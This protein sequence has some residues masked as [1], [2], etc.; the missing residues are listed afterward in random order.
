[1]ATTAERDKATTMVRAN[2]LYRTPVAPPI[3]DTGRNTARSTKAV[4]TIAPDTLRIAAK[5][6]SFGLMPIS[7][8]LYS[9]ASTTTMAS[10]TTIPMASTKANN[11]KVLMVKPK[12]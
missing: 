12:I 1:M 7:S 9:T 8:T 6:A 4:A 5:V 2:C 10:S 3:K 11:V